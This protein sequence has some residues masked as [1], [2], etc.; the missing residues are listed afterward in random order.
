MLFKRKGC[1]Q[2]PAAEATVIEVLSENKYNVAL[3]LIDADS[4]DKDLQYKLL[5]NQIFIIATPTLVYNEE[6]TYKV[7]SVGRVPTIDEIKSILE[8]K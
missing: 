6:D 5:N 7:I 8:G 4:I 3:E 1:S 2:C